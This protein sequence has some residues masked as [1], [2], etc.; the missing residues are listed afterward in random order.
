M[1][2]VNDNKQKEEVLFT[3]FFFLFFS[4]NGEKYFFD[5]IIT[6]FLCFDVKL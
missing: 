3:D 4:G 2:Y 5:V 6:L 1:R